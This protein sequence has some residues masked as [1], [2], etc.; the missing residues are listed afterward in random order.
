[1]RF[2]R[3]KYLSRIKYAGDL[4]PNLCLLKKL[5]RNHLLNI[6]FEN[7]DI[8]YQIPIELS[9]ERFYEKIVENNRGGFCYELNG[10]FYELLLSLGFD[11]KRVSARVF[12]KD[13]E[14]SPEFDHLA[15]IV[16]IGTSEY[17]TDVGFG[18]F[19]FEPLQIQFNK[20]QKDERGSYII[21]KFEGGY[22]RVSKLE[23][24]KATPE[25][26]FKNVERELEEYAEM[27]TYHQSDPNSHFM[28]KRLISL[29]TEN[30]RISISGNTFIRKEK[31]AVT[32]RE[33]KNET[34]FEKELWCK[35]GI[36]LKKPASDNNY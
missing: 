30:G 11:A 23:H 35:F 2:N 3:E 14:Y 32:K 1:M 13:N 10:L 25:F 5:Q 16:K 15:I 28:K 34:D 6:P 9:V 8:H 24:G 19:V 21:D 17:L 29:P 36:T 7:L 12:E 4:K 22:L 33:L 18:E 26:I 20:T 27:C 31:A